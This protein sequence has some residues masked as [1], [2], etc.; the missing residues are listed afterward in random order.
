ML[1]ALEHTWSL[2]EKELIK[3]PYLQYAQVTKQFQK[4]LNAFHNRNSLKE[5][6]SMPPLSKWG[7][8]RSESL[9]NLSKT[10]NYDRARTQCSSH[11]PYTYFYKESPE[12]LGGLISFHYNEETT[13][14]RLRKYRN[15]LAYF[16]LGILHPQE[17][18]HCPYSPGHSQS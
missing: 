4:H 12:K 13:S 7:D 8:W 5:F 2:K 17:C 1:P 16:Y 18:A 9:V 3:R 14:E 11:L 6:S 10:L 15:Y